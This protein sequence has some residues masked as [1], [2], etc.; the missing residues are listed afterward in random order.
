[1]ELTVVALL[2]VPAQPNW[3]SQCSSPGAA[4]VDTAGINNRMPGHTRRRLDRMRRISFM[5]TPKFARINDSR[6]LL[7]SRLDWRNTSKT[8]GRRQVTSA[9]KIVVLRL[10]G[11]G[12]SCRNAEPLGFH[13]AVLVDRVF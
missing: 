4:I 13:S 9:L 6:S 5:I 12:S 2:V 10:R 3:A 7:C 8:A 1:M 11:A